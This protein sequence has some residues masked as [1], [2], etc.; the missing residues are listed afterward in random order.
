MTDR[1]GQQLGNY[2][3]VQLL[4]SGGFADV[5][6]AE[7]IYLKTQVAVKVLQNRL[8]TAEDTNSFLREA[9]LI[10]RLSHPHIVRVL[11]F[12]LDGELPYLVMDYAPSGTLRQL[13]PRGRPLPLTLVVSYVKQLADALHYAHDE[14]VIHRDLKP[15]NM[16]FGKRHQVLLS[17]FGVA[18]A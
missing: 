15:E 14:K 8:S 7:H 2:I 13:H 4:G 16:L 5:Y 12:G 10:A 3:L 6:L 18:L 1:I 9:Q 11:D 17:D